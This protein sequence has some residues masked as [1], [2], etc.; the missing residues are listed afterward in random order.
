MGRLTTLPPLLAALP[1]RFT[2]LTDAEGHS[3]TLEPWRAWYSTPEWRRLR[4]DVFLRDSFTC[5]CGCETL[6]TNPRERIADHK[7]R[8]R[9]DRRLFFDPGNVQTLWKPHHDGWKQRLERAG[10]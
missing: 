6:I 1:S 2:R 5:Q 9:G 4:M 3:R 7:V 8:H 10:G